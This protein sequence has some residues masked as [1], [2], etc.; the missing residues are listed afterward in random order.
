MKQPATF[1]F[2]GFDPET[3]SD[4]DFSCNIETDQCRLSIEW[5]GGDAE[6]V[7]I[8]SDKGT[9]YID[10]NDYEKVAVLCNGEWMTIASLIDWIAANIDSFIAEECEEYYDELR[11]RQELSSPYL[12]GRI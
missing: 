8:N 11:M 6:E 12:S 3:T 2:K 4:R 10:A 5:D 9:T 7:L 1:L